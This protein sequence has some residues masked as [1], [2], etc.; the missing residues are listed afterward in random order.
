MEIH[1]PNFITELREKINE[2][3]NIKPSS[4]DSYIFNIEKLHEKIHG[5]KNIESL[6]FLND[7]E[8]IMKN[9]Y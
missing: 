4:L 8:N 9:F 5:N 2:T 1:N 3:R 7:Y 6:S